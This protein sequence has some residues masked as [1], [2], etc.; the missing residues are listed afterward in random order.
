M[1]VR[2]STVRKVRKVRKHL[3]AFT[4]V[5][6]LVVMAIITLL[7]ALLM[8]GLRS[9]MWQADS[10]VCMSNLRQIA[11]DFQI[12][13][14]N[15]SE[16]K[17]WDPDRA[18][19]TGF[20]LTSFIDKVY[21][22]GK[23]FPAANPQDDQEVREYVRGD[24]IFFCPSGPP[25]MRIREGRTVLDYNNEAILEPENVSYGFNARLYKVYRRVAGTEVWRDWFVTLS[26]NLYN[27]PRA[28][29]TALVLDVDARAA[30]KAGSLPHLIAPPLE[31][32][33][34]Y[35]PG[36]AMTLVQGQHWFPS[37]RHRGKTNIAL[38]DGSVQSEADL[39]GRP[40]HINWADATYTGEWINGT[41]ALS[42][43]QGMSGSLWSFDSLSDEIVY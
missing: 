29:K 15:A 13:T 26:P 24:N 33:G 9:V 11:F 18:A 22:A 5:E 27:W 35:V 38:L 39:L 31:P 16:L 37:R 7:V 30:H 10:L 2:M 1:S 12:V 6:M 4:L 8:T 21:Q 17:R 25:R 34:E 19:V 40:N 42:G 23:Y 14:Q 36:E 20:G 28:P 3:Q 43:P 32:G 41:Y